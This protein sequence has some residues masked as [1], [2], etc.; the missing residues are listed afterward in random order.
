MLLLLLQLYGEFA[1]RF[2]LSECKLAVIHCAGHDDAIL[3]EALWQDIIE[4][5][6]Y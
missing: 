5:G 1:D 4:K 3:V 2:D 6:L